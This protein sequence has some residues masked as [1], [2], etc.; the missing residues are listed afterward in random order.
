[1]SDRDAM[2]KDYVP[3]EPGPASGVE[4]EQVGRLQ[5][6]LERFGYLRSPDDEAGDIAP[7]VTGSRALQATAGVFDEATY[8]AL[9]R[10]QS[11]TGLPVT[12]VLD[13]ATVAQMSRPRCGFPD[14]PIGGTPVNG[15]P[16]ASFVAQGSRWTTTNLRYGFQNF[17]GDLTQAQVRTT[18][19]AAFNLWSRVTPLRF[20]EVAV[21]NTPQ[22]IIRFAAGD[23][24]DGHAFDGANGVL[25]H[26][27]YPPPAGGSLAGD[28]HFDEAETWTV[29]LPVPA[30]G[31]DLFTVA[32]HEF[33][34]SLG[35]AHSADAG[36]LMY[37]YYGGPHRYLGADDVLGIQTIYGAAIKAV[38]GWF[39]AENQ[40]ADI[41]LADING[42]GR[43]D[44][45]VF[46]VD[47]PGGENHGYYRVISDF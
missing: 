40:G 30:G 37:P 17:T 44:L 12:G 26:A 29:A 32:A 36:A 39:G 34:H 4:G 41:A 19:R 6:Y 27:Y 18:I 43:P 25:A 38:P 28:A 35:L 1:M 5:A 9:R 13:E 10:F 21:A 20:T 46:H 8:A 2:A 16:V 47:N 33:G 42:N 15:S 23:H 24:G 22:I 45:V 14:V 11:F 31:Y 7:M 3:T